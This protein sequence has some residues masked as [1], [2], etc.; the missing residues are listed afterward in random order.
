MQKTSSI[1]HCLGLE[2]SLQTNH[3]FLFLHFYDVH[4]AYEAP[5][6]FDTA[7][8]RAPQKGD[9]KYKNYF[10]FKKKKVKADQ[11][12]ASNRSI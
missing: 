2:N 8:D 12:D 10:H 1:R 7:F 4:Y 6:P 3:Y 9:L 5:A 11:E